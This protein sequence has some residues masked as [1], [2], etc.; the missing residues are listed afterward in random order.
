MKQIN[1][2]P[3]ISVVYLKWLLKSFEIYLG[4]A[5]SKIVWGCAFG[6]CSCNRSVCFSIIA[7]SRAAFIRSFWISWPSCL[8]FKLDFDFWR[9]IALS[10]ASI[11]SLRALF[12]F[13]NRHIFTWWISEFKMNLLV[14]G[15]HF[16]WRQ[17]SNKIWRQLSKTFSV[18]SVDY[19]FKMASLSYFNNSWSS[20]DTVISGLITNLCKIRIFLD[21]PVREIYTIKRADFIIFFFGARRPSEYNELVFF[22]KALLFRSWKG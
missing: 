1:Q 20:L 2:Y 7:V 9:S 3:F 21:I 8:A 4:T 17:L 15:G 14:R 5:S 19:K 13:F 12:F 10:M 22:K 16:I 18:T 6:T 11:C